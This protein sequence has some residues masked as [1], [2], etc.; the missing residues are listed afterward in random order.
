MGYASATILGQLVNNLGIAISE[1]QFIG[2]VQSP[3]ITHRLGHLQ[4]GIPSLLAQIVGTDVAGKDVSAEES[5]NTWPASENL[6]GE[7]LG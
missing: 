1:Q 4:P 7:S 2:D 6:R 3:T 5:T